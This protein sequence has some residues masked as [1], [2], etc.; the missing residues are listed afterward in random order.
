LLRRPRHQAG[1]SVNYAFLKKG[2][3]N[4]GFTYVG[5]RRDYWKYPYYS[6]MNP[7]Y[8]V[9]LAASWWIIEQLQVFFRIENML[10]MKYEEVR[11]Y[12]TMPCSVYG[13]LKAMI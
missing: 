11:G 1:V 9:D 13:G 10:N 2:N 8:K 3:I 12:K 7:Y 5:E 4:L 6:S